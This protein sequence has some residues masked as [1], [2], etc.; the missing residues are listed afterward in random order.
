MVEHLPNES[1][2]A[3]SCTIKVGP[4][5]PADGQPC[6][7]VCGLYELEQTRPHLLLNEL[8]EVIHLPARLGHHPRLRS[9]IDLLSDELEECRIGAEALTPALLEVI[10]LLVL[11]AW[12]ADQPCP[13]GEPGWASAMRDPA[14]STALDAIH[15]NPER[16]WTV[17]SLGSHSGLSRAAFARRFSSLLSQPPLAYLT[18]WR[19]TV[20]ARLLR[21]SD[22][23][24][25]SIAREVG[26]ASEFA[27]ANA[28]KREFGRAPGQY[29]RG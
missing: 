29:R 7:M 18:W 22:R 14:I 23:P 1:E 19:M 9:A 10:L 12:I 21:D 13:E 4:D 28:F 15:S 17:E 27:F 2:R 26:Y 25:S 6:L 3:T 20:A 5:G 11:R 24:L 8:P 16:A